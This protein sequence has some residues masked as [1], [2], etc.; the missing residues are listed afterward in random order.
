MISS[1]S[2]EWERGDRKNIV[3]SLLM[4]NYEHV[5]MNMKTVSE[6]GFREEKATKVV[7]SSC[8][9]CILEARS[10]EGCARNFAL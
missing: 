10:L 8:S 5:V 2:S 9:N 6:N 4:L 7:G 1:R 3:I